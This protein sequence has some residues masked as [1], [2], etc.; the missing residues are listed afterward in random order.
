MSL[1]EVAAK[2]G[3]SRSF[4]SKAERGFSST[5][6][7]SL[8]RWTAA[9]DIS[10][11]S[12]FE[13]RPGLAE[14]R[15]LTPCYET[16]GVKE[17]LLTPLEERRFEV[18]EEHLEPGCGPDRRYWSVDADFAFVYVI[19]GRLEIVFGHDEHRVELETGDLHV[20]S[21]RTPHRW[22]NTSS[23]RTVALVCDSPASF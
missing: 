10:M 23:E 14:N 8:L 7:S 17:Y 3:F 4:L 19:S 9:L 21:P 11:A 18:F 2:T 5:S 1:A 15:C 12:L 16:N 22:M 13:I 20:Y 6:L